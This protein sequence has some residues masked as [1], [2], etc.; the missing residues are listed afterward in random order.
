VDKIHLAQDRVQW[1]CSCE[2][3][4]TPSCSIKGMEFLDKLSD[5][6]IEK[7]LARQLHS[8]TWVIYSLNVKLKITF[9]VIIL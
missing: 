4:N 1:V 5:L 9:A 6:Q 2:H 3:G 7:D 8:H